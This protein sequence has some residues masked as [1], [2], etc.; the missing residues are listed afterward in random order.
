MEPILKKLDLKK[1]S[2]V[3]KSFMIYNYNL[4]IKL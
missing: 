2:L 1:A 4:E 3:L